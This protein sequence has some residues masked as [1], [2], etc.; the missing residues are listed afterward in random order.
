[1]HF[2]RLPRQSSPTYKA[3]RL[4]V[5]NPG[6][7]GHAAVSTV[8]SAVQ[9]INQNQPLYIEFVAQRMRMLELML[10]GGQM[11]VIFARMRLMSV[12]EN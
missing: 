6:H 2:P 12:K 3:E 7:I 5:K 4:T 10:H 1:M 11:W 9:C 8:A